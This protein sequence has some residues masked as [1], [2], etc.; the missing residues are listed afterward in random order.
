MGLQTG[1]QFLPYG[2]NMKWWK[3]RTQSKCPCCSCPEEDKEHIMQ[4]LAASIVAQWRKAHEELDNWMVATK[5]HPH[6]H[7][8]II[9]RLQWWHNDE[10]LNQMITEGSNAGAIQ[11]AIGWEIALAGCLALHWRVE[12]D[13]YWKAFKSRKSSEQWT[14]V[15]IIFDNDS[16]GYVATPE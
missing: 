3:L 14:M 15:L 4:C 6:L 9:S 8:D 13:I 10:M 2:M 12:H 5:T 11:D 16:L 7:Q 1:N